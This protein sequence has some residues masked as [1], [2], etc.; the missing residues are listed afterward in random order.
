[1]RERHDRP[2]LAAVVMVESRR[3]INRQI[4][5]ETRYYIT[6]LALPASLVAPIVRGHWAIENSQHWVTNMVFRDDE[7]RASIDQ[8]QPIASQS[9]RWP[10][11]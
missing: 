1:M 3:E 5:A 4:T 7:S 8:R 9:S 11:T 10:Q 6:S 2:S